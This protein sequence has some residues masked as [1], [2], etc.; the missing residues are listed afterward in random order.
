MPQISNPESPVSRAAV[1][2]SIALAAFALCFWVRSLAAYTSAVSGERVP[3]R[4]AEWCAAHP[5][6]GKLFNDDRA[7]GYLSWKNP[8][9]K[10]FIDGRFIL[11]SAQFFE[12]YL[13]YAS[14]PDSFIADADSLDIGRAVLPLRYYAKWG[15]LIPELLKT[16]RWHIVYRDEFYTVLDKR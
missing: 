9:E 11:R 6:P 12:R 10:T 7:G 16:D 8:G 13:N 2:I 5:H 4:A 1:F 14:A 3:V 15:R